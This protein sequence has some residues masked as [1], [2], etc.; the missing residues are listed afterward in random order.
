MCELLLES[1]DVD[2]PRNFVCHNIHETIIMVLQKLEYRFENCYNRIAFGSFKVNKMFSLLNM[3]VPVLN[4]SKMRSVNKIL[5]LFGHILRL[6]NHVKASGRSLLLT[7]KS[8]LT[9]NL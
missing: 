7:S 3:P 5:M 6:K 4:P 8:K 2:S 1:V 9:I